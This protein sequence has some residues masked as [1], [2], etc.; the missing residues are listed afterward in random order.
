MESEQPKL[1]MQVPCVGGQHHQLSAAITAGFIVEGTAVSLERQPDNPYDSN[2]V[3]VMLNGTELGNLQLGYVK[4]N[5]AVD[6]SH[7]MDKGGMKFTA[8]VAMVR[9]N[10]L[11]LD[12][13]GY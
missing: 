11:M 1:R 13:E 10:S 4:K 7:H 9:A 5:F 6:L 12:V 2:A 3:K 8:R